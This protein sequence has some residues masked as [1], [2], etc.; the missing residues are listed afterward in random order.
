MEKNLESMRPHMTDFY[1]QKAQKILAG[2]A[3]L[4]N[5]MKNIHIHKM[6]L[7][8]VRNYPGKD[9]DMFAMEIK[10]SM[11]DYTIH[12]S[13]GTFVSS[14][15]YRN[16]NEDFKSYENRAKTEAS[17]F[18][19]YYIF[20]RVDNT[21]KLNNI[22][23]EFSIIRDVIGLSE[24]K[25]K[26]ILEQEKNSTSVNDDVFYNTSVDKNIKIKKN[27]PKNEKTNPSMS[28]KIH[29]FQNKKSPKRGFFI[30]HHQMLQNLFQQML[31]HFFHFHALSV[32]VPS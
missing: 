12:E 7:M 28:K 23:S 32:Q 9:G 13:D 6:E 24:S 2:E 10:G 19:E 29:F 5:I 11:I 22:K 1:Y 14:P 18:T 4:K 31:E 3:G 27:R 25:L 30:L 21:W 16:K 17:S 15:T 8:S 26:Q 20:I